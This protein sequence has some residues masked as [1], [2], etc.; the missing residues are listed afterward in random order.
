MLARVRNRRGIVAAVNPYDGEAGRLHLVQVAYKDHDSPHSERLLWELE[1]GRELLEPSRMPQVHE[2]GPMPADDFDA[3]L[4]AARW[5]SLM[6]Y[7]D[8]DGEGPLDRQPVSSP[9]HSGIRVEDYQLVPLLQALR[10]PRVNLLIADD[11][12]LGKTVEAGLILKELLL[13]RRI[14]RVLILVPAAL[15]LQWRDELET[16]FALPF[17]IVDRGRTEQLRRELGIDASPWRSFSRIIASYHYLR[18]PDIKEQFLAASQTPEGSPRLPWDL[19]IVDECHNLM[20]SPFGD[21]SELCQ[22]LRQVAPCFEHRLFLSATPHN[23]HTRSFTG[24]LEVLDPVRVSQTDELTARQRARIGQ[25]VV[26]RLKR[27][28][29]QQS[30]APRFCKRNQPQPLLLDRDRREAA[31]SDAFDAFR[32]AVRSTIAAGEVGERAGSFAIEILGKRLLSCPTA[33]ADSWRRARDGYSRADEA[34]RTTDADVAAAK[35]SVER[36]SS[37]DRE[38]E[39]RT[40]TA[41]GVVGAWLRNVAGAV[42]HEMAAIDDALETLGFDLVGPPTV[43]QNPEVDAR[44]DALAALIEE[45]LLVPGGGNAATRF[46]DDERLIVFT[47]YKT[48]LDY[49]ERRLREHYDPGNGDPADGARI[50]TLF[51]SGGVGGMDDAA[52]NRVREAFNAP[53]SSVRILVA[54]DAASEGLNLHRS[55]RYLLHYDCPWNPSRLEQRNGRLD[56]YGQARDVTVH[57]FLS[58]DDPD[59]KFLDHVIRKADEIRAD[60]GSVNELFD[61][62]AH[63]RLIEGADLSRVQ[64]ELDHKLT[65][66]IR[67]VQDQIPELFAAAEQTD[68]DKRQAPSEPD[69][70]R[71]DGDDQNASGLLRNLA[72]EIDFDPAALR[73]TL[74]AA[75]AINVG[76]PQ[77]DRV[78]SA[79]AQKRGTE[80]DFWRVLRTDLPGW[81]DTIDESLRLPSP[82][83]VLGATQ[84]LAF[85]PDSLLQQVGE[86][87]V[88]SPRPEV[89]LLHLAHPMVE[90]ALRVLTMRR[91]PG[92]GQV[93]RWTVRRGGVPRGFD[94]LILL[95]LEELAVNELRETFHHWVRTLTLPVRDGVLEEP[96]AHAPARNLAST[97]Y[98]AGAGS[99]PDNAAAPTPAERDQAQK[100]FLSVEA[101]LEGVAARHAD[102]LTDSLHAQ[103]RTDGDSALKRENDR[104][105]SRQGE[106]SQLIEQ[107][108]LKRLEREIDKLRREQ[109][110]RLLFEQ[111]SSLDRLASSIQEKQREIERRRQH[112]EDARDQLERER[113]RIVNR[114]LP[115]R[116]SLAGKAQAF[117]VTIEVRLP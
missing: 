73:Q 83:G 16:K 59:L 92:S 12:G 53:E 112:Y 42:E 56:R 94:A 8:P 21:D 76:R 72:S 18:Q 90:R 2:T 88:F 50:L 25:L 10:M 98:V 114:L 103:L 93:A 45:L 34:A 35:R 64:F 75:M 60:L 111:R 115:K 104:Y 40:G 79:A 17:E 5:T 11:V 41:A 91:L 37:D 95:S 63:K 20:P 30:A 100:I 32:K 29:N 4:R 27:E 9:L 22:M 81:R 116:H 47:E 57:H 74:E 51:G 82:D 87:D 52:R 117:P 54:T 108:S 66:E 70:P 80:A 113:K 106:V 101:A 77:V 55:A 102:E 7:L 48:T 13:R 3:L 38:T 97:A 33:F 109:Q 85:D 58:D 24:L 110:Q 61:T 1:P 71:P 26:R 31:L 36:E 15:R 105:R 62:A 89:A 67:R 99:C 28:L 39:Q 65:R 86:R 14:R 49:L 46:R 44:F 43:E 107:A 96:M 19:L 69:L 68:V 78:R 23:G 6:P 84:H